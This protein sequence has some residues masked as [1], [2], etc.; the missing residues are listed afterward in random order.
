MMTNLARLFKS[1]PWPPGEP[2]HGELSMRV[3]KAPFLP[4]VAALCGAL[5]LADM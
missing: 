2:G 5:T 4:V 1:S 3:S